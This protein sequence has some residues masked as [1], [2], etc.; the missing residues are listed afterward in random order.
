MPF[1]DN[2]SIKGLKTRY[3]NKE[4]EPSIRRFV[5]EYL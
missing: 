2:I 3:N 1:L 4:V 5:L